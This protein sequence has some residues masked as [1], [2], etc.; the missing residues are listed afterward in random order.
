[1][2]SEGAYR[3]VT[4]CFDHKGN[5]LSPVGVTP[6]YDTSVTFPTFGIVKPAVANTRVNM[7]PLRAIGVCERCGRHTGG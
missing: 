5:E 3:I 1:M 4:V 7:S 2:E 6:V